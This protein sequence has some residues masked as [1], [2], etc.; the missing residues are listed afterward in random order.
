MND[1]SDEID[2]ARD[3]IKS[4][5]AHNDYVNILLNPIAGKIVY[6]ENDA[7]GINAHSSYHML[8]SNEYDEN[9]NIVS[10]RKQDIKSHALGEVTCGVSDRLSML[11]GS[12][13]GDFSGLLAAMV[14]GILSSE[15]SENYEKG[16][17]LD[18]TYDVGEYLMGAGSSIAINPNPTA[19]AMKLS[20]HSNEAIYG[21]FVKSKNAIEDV[22]LRVRSIENGLGMITSELDLNNRIDCYI[23]TKIEGI[24]EKLKKNFRDIMKY[25]DGIQSIGNMYAESEKEVSNDLMKS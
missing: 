21:D 23:S 16:R 12:G 8:I 11:P 13:N 25:S 1:Y 5:S 17:V 9:G 24:Q 20:A 14:A 15:K 19:A 7:K 18:A 6:T 2:S 22:G 3:K 10:L 4:V